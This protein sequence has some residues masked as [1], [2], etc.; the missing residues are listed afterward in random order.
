MLQRAS[1]VGVPW[2]TWEHADM[3][4]I[5]AEDAFRA[6]GFGAD[7]AAE[8]SRRWRSVWR[9]HFYAGMFAMPFIV[10]M[11]LTGLV[12]LYTQP[13]EDLTQGD[14]R[15]VQAPDDAAA[16]TVSFDEQVAA[17]QVAYPDGTVYD[18]TPPADAGRASRFFVDDG[19][20]NGLHVFVDPYT[21]EVL[22]DT[23]PGG[24][25]IGLSNRLHGFL[26]NESV[27]VP[28]PSVAALW[29]DDPVMRDYVLGDLVLEIL[30]VWTLVLICSGLFIWFPRRSAASNGSAPARRT[31]FVRRGVTGRAR[32]RDLHGFGG[33]LLFA[34]MAL[35]IVS[36]MA[37]STYWGAQFG[38]LADAVTPGDWVDAP[39]STLGVRGDLD[40]FG[41]QIPWNTGEFPIPA[42][43]APEAVDGSMPAPLSLDA[44]VAIAADEGMRPGYTISFPGNDV[45]EAGNPVYGSF[46]LYNSWP[47]KTG[48]ARDVFVDQ[49]SGATLAEQNVYGYG[50]VARGMDYLVS[51]HMGTQLGIVS[52]IFMTLLC[53]L[54]IWSVV[55]GFVMFWKRRRA[56]SLGLPRRPFDVRLARGVVISAVVLGVVYPQWGVTALVILGLDRFVIRRVPRLRTTFGQVGGA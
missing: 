37:W 44:L 23:K 29:D 4:D 43:Y 34:V 33:V 36:G 52:R 12:I 13:I 26:N 48:E 38:S 50:T 55:S 49:F 54:S 24:G 19:S 42:S 9:I 16:A 7:E 39:A 11:A 17:V 22:G 3:T 6:T 25:I 31:W 1:V 35:T 5:S 56:G 2:T 27:T 47:R 20:V 32:W 41:N 14:V 30:G 46:T 40:R 18:L 28:L 53:V 51:T 8:R 15:T 21:A 45:D 10:L